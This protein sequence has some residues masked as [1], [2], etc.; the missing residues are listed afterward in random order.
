MLFCQSSVNSNKSYKGTVGKFK[1]AKT[2]PAV[3]DPVFASN[4][5]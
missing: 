3:L 5:F 4:G 2:N 1:S